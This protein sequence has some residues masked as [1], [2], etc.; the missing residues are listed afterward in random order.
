MPRGS[1]VTV[2]TPLAMGRRVR[3]AASTLRSTQRLRLCVGK[4]SAIGQR[5]HR[6]IRLPGVLGMPVQVAKLEIFEDG[7]MAIPAETRHR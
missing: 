2:C 6:L 1:P 7:Q 5:T 3:Q 4:E